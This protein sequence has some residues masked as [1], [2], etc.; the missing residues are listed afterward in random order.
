MNNIIC[1]I[2]ISN[3]VGKSFLSKAFKIYTIRTKFD[4]LPAKLLKMDMIIIHKI[5][6]TSLYSTHLNGMAFFYCQNV[7]FL[8]IRI[9]RT[10]CNRYLLEIGSLMRFVSRLINNNI[11]VDKNYDL[12]FLPCSTIS[13][14]SY[15]P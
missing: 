13:R 15:L 4:T 5:N 6:E 14:D 10:R 11:K 1:S 12:L 9:H 8:V 7:C 3:N 2:S